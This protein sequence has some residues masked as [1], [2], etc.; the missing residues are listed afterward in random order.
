MAEK[1]RRDQRLGRD[2]T[3][4]ELRRRGF[5]TLS[6]CTVGP[7]RIEGCRLAEVEA[8]V[9]TSRKLV[10]PPRS[11][12]GEV[13]G[14]PVE[15]PS[16]RQT[17]DEEPPGVA[18]ARP[19]LQPLA[20]RAVVGRIRVEAHP[21]PD[22]GEEG[23]VIQLF[24]DRQVLLALRNPIAS[25]FADTL[26]GMASEK[27]TRDRDS[28]GV[29]HG[30]LYSKALWYSQNAMSKGSSTWTGTGSPNFRRSTQLAFSF[31][32]RS[33]TFP[34]IA[35]IGTIHGAPPLKLS[36]LGMPLTPC[37]APAKASARKSE[38]CRALFR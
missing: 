1:P 21:G 15:G 23:G 16:R 27:R 4:V 25:T 14:A 31:S 33:S 22:S 17:Y 30:G 19:A 34:S 6:L 35:L 37:R 2:G 36:C 12:V 18:E 28:L 20:Q 13:G 32:N 5:P 8:G 26:L 29:V 11:A 7:R 38:T 3:G 10:Q 9:A 24:L